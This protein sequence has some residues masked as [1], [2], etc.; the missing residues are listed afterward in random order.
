M[1][2]TTNVQTYAHDQGIKLVRLLVVLD[3]KI[4]V[5]ILM[6][7]YV[8]MYLQYIEKFMAIHIWHMP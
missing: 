4:V 6:C 1:H 5:C 7:K 8:C 2:V 3:L